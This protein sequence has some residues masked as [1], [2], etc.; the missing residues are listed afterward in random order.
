MS[1]YLTCTSDKCHKCSLAETHDWFIDRS[2]VVLVAIWAGFADQ[3][4]LQDEYFDRFVFFRAWFLGPLPF[5]WLCT[6][7][8]MFL[9]TCLSSRALE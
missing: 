5:A 6:L 1:L 3:G 8:S 9:S 7:P 4:S 2:G